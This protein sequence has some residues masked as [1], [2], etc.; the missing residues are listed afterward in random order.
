MVGLGD[1]VLRL[2]LEH[3]IN[4]GLMVI[5]FFV[6]GL[7]MKR[8]LVLGELRDPR[9]AALPIVARAR[10]HGR[11]G[12]RLSGLAGRRTRRRAAGASRWRPTSR[13]SSAAWR[14]SGRACRRA[15]DHAADA[16]DRRRHR[17]DP[18][19]R[20]RL[21]DRRPCA[22]RSRSASRA[23]PSCSRVARLGVRSLGVYT[24][25]ACSSGSPSCTRACTRRSPAW[26]SAC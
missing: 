13:S 21:C 6:V 10:R 22:A 23:S 5:F 12:R 16:R 26:C 14:C 24:S 2:S 17:R 25:S 9:R 11:A 3:W 1:F 8:E 7:E 20:G 18:G 19:D 15:P 4:D